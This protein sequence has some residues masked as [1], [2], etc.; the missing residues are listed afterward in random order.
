VELAVQMMSGFSDMFIAIIQ[1][2]G[3]FWRETGHYVT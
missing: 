2:I 3:V 1:I